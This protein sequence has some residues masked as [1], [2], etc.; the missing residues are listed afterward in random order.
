MCSKCRQIP[1]HIFKYIYC[2]EL[3]GVY[4]SNFEMNEA[5][6]QAKRINCKIVNKNENTFTSFLFTK[7]EKNTTSTKISCIIWP[8]TQL[9]PHKLWR[10]CLK[11][12][13]YSMTY[14]PYPALDY[15]RDNS[16]HYFFFQKPSTIFEITVTRFLLFFFVFPR[17]T[18]GGT[19]LVL[20]CTI[21]LQLSL[22]RAQTFHSSATTSKAWSSQDTCVMYMYNLYYVI[23]TMYLYKTCE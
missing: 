4:F 3:H 22:M 8:K 18:I 12:N 2:W 13:S 17:K 10:H 21:I 19:A 15:C 6:S 20:H 7:N 1:L 16:S 5:S 23:Y 14:P 11:Y 9:K